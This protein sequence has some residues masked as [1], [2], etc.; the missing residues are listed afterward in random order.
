MVLLL[1]SATVKWPKDYRT[2]DKK[3]KKKG[4]RLDDFP[5]SWILLYLS[6]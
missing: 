1:T 3:K 6:G 5:L 4:F 2:K